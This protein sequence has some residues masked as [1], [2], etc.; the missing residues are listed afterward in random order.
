MSVNSDKKVYILLTRKI[1]YQL[2]LGLVAL[3]LIMTNEMAGFNVTSN[4]MLFVCTKGSIS[5]Q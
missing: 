2:E 1:S 4:K 3:P 5:K